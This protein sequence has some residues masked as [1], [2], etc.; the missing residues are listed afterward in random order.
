MDAMVD[1]AIEFRGLPH[2]SEFIAE[3]D[4]VTWINDSKGTN[5]GAAVAA[6][7]GIETPVVLIAGGDAK[8]ARF[9]ALAEALRGR[10]RAAVLIGRDA[11]RLAEALEPVGPVET[12]AD[13]ES[14]VA[15]AAALAERGDTVVLAPACASLD[16]YA[17]Y[18]ARGDAFRAAVEGLDP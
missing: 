9:D 8:G 16:M 11:P 4:G 2:R 15:R 12:A 18:R 10:L 14:A 7:Q 5:V 3:R 13:M 17:D 1:A 6:V